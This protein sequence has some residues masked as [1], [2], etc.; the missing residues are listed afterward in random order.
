MKNGEVI[1]AWDVV[2]PKTYTNQM[3]IRADY[4]NTKNAIHIWDELYAH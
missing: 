4:T 2:N 1:V 3:H